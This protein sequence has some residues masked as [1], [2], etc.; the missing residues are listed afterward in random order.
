MW[1]SGGIGGEI[2][3]EIREMIG[4]G[5]VGDIGCGK[6]SDGGGRKGNFGFVICFFLRSVCKFVENI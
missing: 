1:I 4:G 5:F 6:Y 3:G 2:G